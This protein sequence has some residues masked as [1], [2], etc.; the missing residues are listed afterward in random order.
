MLRN[1][2]LLMAVG[3]MRVPNTFGASPWEL[4]DET[5]E[6][7]GQQWMIGNELVQRVVVFQAKSGLFTEQLSR[8]SLKIV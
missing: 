8:N 7:A 2:A 5:R 3:S 6:I 1:G 4:Q